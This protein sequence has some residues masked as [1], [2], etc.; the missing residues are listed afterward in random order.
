MKYW[1]QKKAFDHTKL[2]QARH[3]FDQA[4]NYHNYYR[5]LKIPYVDITGKITYLD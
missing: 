5:A 3:A 4:I 2:F 1:T